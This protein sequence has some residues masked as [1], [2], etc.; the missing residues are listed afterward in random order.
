MHPNF[1]SKLADVF[2]LALTKYGV[3]FIIETHSEYLIRKLQYLVMKK[4]LLKDKIFIY[5]LDKANDLSSVSKI[6]IKE[7]GYLTKNFGTGFLDE[8]NN[9]SIQLF[10]ERSHLNN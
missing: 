10:I 5:Y 8:A 6:E 9:I 4:E 7:N 1:Q 2:C 3:S